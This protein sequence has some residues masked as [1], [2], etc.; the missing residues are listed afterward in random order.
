MA[1]VKFHT[2]SESH[3][4]FFPLNE[5]KN[6]RGLSSCLCCHRSETSVRSEI[7]AKIMVYTCLVPCKCQQ[8]DQI[9]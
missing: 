4:A 3:Q 5:Y 7:K 6:C 2:K 8:N 9:E 1:S